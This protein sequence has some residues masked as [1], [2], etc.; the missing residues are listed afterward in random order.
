MWAP[1]ASY[2]AA[3]ESRDTARVREAYPK[4]SKAQMQTMQNAFALTDSVRA[5]PT[6]DGSPTRTGETA[7]LPFT[8]HFG[9]VYHATKSPTNST[10]HY[11][12]VLSRD[13]KRWKLKE[14]VDR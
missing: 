5:V 2:A 13:G 11:V 6:P 1:I 14:L 3:W 7:R 9:F 4:T 12:A 10:Q 8:L